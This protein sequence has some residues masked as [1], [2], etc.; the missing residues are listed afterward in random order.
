MVVVVEAMLLKKH[1]FRPLFYHST[2]VHCKSA[3]ALKVKVAKFFVG[4][5]YIIFFPKEKCGDKIN[6]FGPFIHT[7]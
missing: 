2:T 6:V 4:M 7:I 3:T 1:T 5:E